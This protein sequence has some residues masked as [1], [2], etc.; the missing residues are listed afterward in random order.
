MIIL[1]TNDLMFQSRVSAAVR[2]AGKTFLVDRTVSKLQERCEDASS[3]ELVLI[4]LAF[5]DLDLS[6]GVTELRQAFGQA[7]VIAFGPHVDVPRLNLAQE[8]GCDVVMT[9][10]QFDR[11]LAEIVSQ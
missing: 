6:S 3:V 9:R 8:V 7:K 5:Q 1:L 10:G 2:N 11:D 4:D